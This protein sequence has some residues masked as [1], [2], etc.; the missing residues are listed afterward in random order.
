MANVGDDFLLLTTEVN[1]KYGYHKKDFHSLK[2]ICE[3]CSPE[4]Q[5]RPVWWI[6]APNLKK[7]ENIAEY[8]SLYSF[9][10]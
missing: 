1:L 2:N 9:V 4:K 7:K 10:F 3:M 5:I 8:F 6:F